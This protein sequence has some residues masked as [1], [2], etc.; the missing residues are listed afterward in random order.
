M[1]QRVLASEGTYTNATEPEN[2]IMS[3]VGGQLNAART[4]KSYD[5]N[6][7]NGSSEDAFFTKL[8]TYSFSDKNNRS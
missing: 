3:Y 7:G 8:T 6:L 1:E 2:A 4:W 5:D